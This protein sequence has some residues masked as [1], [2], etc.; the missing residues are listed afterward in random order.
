M[1]SLQELAVKAE[2]WDRHGKLE[3]VGLGN[4]ILIL[5]MAWVSYPKNG[6]I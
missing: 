2:S 1:R 3:K 5:L 4:C 6:Q